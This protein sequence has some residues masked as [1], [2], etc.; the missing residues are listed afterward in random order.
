V[1]LELLA[2]GRDADVFAHEPGKVLR[3]Y[4]DGSDV[5]HEAAVMAYLG[6]QGFP[7]PEVFEADQTDLVMERVDGPTLLKAITTGEVE[8]AD[9]MWILADLLNRLHLLPGRILHM[10]LHPDNI[11]LGPYG[12]V[13]IDWR[14]CREGPADLDTAMSALILAQVAVHPGYRLV[15]DLRTFLSHV[16]GRPQDMLPAAVEI[17]RTDPNLTG[18]ELD[19]LAEARTFLLHGFEAV[20]HTRLGQ[21][22]PGM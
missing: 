8:M 13:V 11:L 7:V 16:H 9:G 19:Q 2:S 12:P 21:Q 10:D 14:N 4:R 1:V 6:E 20:A 17:R 18:A 15:P 22:M 5:A 3:R